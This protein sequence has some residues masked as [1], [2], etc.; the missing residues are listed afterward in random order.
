[1]LGDPSSGI[2]DNSRSGTLPGETRL[3]I[4]EPTWKSLHRKAVEA[5]VGQA[6]WGMRPLAN[7]EVSCPPIF[8]GVGRERR[9]VESHR[10]PLQEGRVT[11][12]GVALSCLGVEVQV[13]SVP[14]IW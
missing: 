7:E 2:W 3:T 5:L 11:S 10:P 9:P 1:M 14:N 12:H 4:G 13:Y 8:W 6:V